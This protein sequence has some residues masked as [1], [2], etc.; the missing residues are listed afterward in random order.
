MSTPAPLVP[1]SPSTPDTMTMTLDEIRGRFDDATRA[2]EGG[3]LVLDT[4]LLTACGVDPALVASLPGKRLRLFAPVIGEVNDGV[5][6]LE[7]DADVAGATRVR[8]R[9]EVRDGSGGARAFLSAGLDG[10]WSFR[11]ALPG[12]PGYLAPGGGGDLP[13][14]R[15]SF[16]Y[17]LDV[18]A[19][20]VLLS[21][22][23]FDD[24]RFGP[25][26]PGLNLAAGVRLEGPL[27][28]IQQWGVVP[29]GLSL[30]G[31]LDLSGARPFAALSIKLP[32]AF[33]LG[34]VS[35]DDV[36]LGLFCVPRK[37][38]RRMDVGMELDAGVRL[39]EVA[40]QL[41]SR[42]EPGSSR[43]AL[44]GWFTG[45]S[46]RNLQALA[47]DLG[48]PDLSSVLPP[49]L[50]DLPLPELR[51]GRVVF[52]L[53]A[54]TLEEVRL[55]VASPAPWPLL[56]GLTLDQ[57]RFELGI[58]RPLDSTR[59]VDAM[60]RG[61]FQLADGSFLFLQGSY[62]GFAIAGG[63]EEG[64]TL[65][66]NALLANPTLHL[67]PVSLPG[68]PV[69]TD[70]GFEATPGTGPYAFHLGVEG[71]WRLPLELP[72]GAGITLEEL[73]LA[74]RY[75][76]RPS[77]K[78]AGRIDVL[79]VPLAGSAELPAEGGTGVI[80]EAGT[81]PGEDV[82]LRQLAGSL[83][84]AAQ[85]P[86]P[87]IEGDIL[88]RDVLLRVDTRPE[89]RAFVLN[90]SSSLSTPL[91]LPGGDAPLDLWLGLRD[92][93]YDFA[94]G[95][96]AGY[97]EGGIRF[98]TAELTVTAD[99]GQDERK[100][101]F[102]QGAAP[103]DIGAILSRFVPGGIALPPELPGI[104]GL[105]IS[106]VEGS[107]DLTTHAYAF[108]GTASI[109]R[110]TA[111]TLTLSE[112]TGSLSLSGTG[113]ALQELTVTVSA[114]ARQE[115]VPELQVET[116]TFELHLKRGD[117]GWEWRVGGSLAIR[118]L[119][120]PSLT[121]KADAGN[122]RFAFSAVPESPLA[123]SVPGVVEGSFGRLELE[124]KRAESGAIAWHLEGAGALK[125]ASLPRASG[126]L[127]IYDEPGKKGFAFTAD[128]GQ[129]PLTVE[130]PLVPG[131]E[132]MT[133]G[134]T[135]RLDQFSILKEAEWEVAVESTLRLIVPR[136]SSPQSDDPVDRSL[137]L[138]NDLLGNPVTARLAA[139]AAGVT[140]HARNLPRI[141]IPVP[142]VVNGE[143]VMDRMGRIGVDAI[144]LR[145]GSSFHAE[146][147]LALTLPE[148]INNVFGEE[149]GKPR[150]RLLNRE[151]RVTLS[152][153]SARGLG[154]ELG[155]SPIDLRGSGLFA[156]EVEETPA[157]PRT[158]TRF[159]LGPVTFRFAEIPDPQEAGKKW[160]HFDFAELGEVA[161]LK[162]RLTFD[163][164]SFAASGG[165][166]IVRDV[167]LPAGPLRAGMRQ[168]GLN[169]L[170]DA[171]PDSIPLLDLHVLRDDGAG[172]R[173]FDADAFVDVL[174]R[175][176]ADTG[177]QVPV[178]EL[179]PVVRLLAGQ[180]NRLPEGF[181]EYLDVTIPRQLELDIAFTPSAGFGLKLDVRAPRD[182]LR[183]LVPTPM[184]FQGITL[185]K[186]ALGELLSGS[187]LL[188][189]VDVA[190]DQ[191][192]I[193]SLAASLFL[194]AEVADTFTRTTAIQ[195]RLVVRDVMVLVIL[196]TQVPIP[197]P[198]W[199]SQVGVQRYGLEGLEA[200]ALLNNNLA[201]VTLVTALRGLVD[202]Y[203]E[204]RAFFTDAD[205]L[206]PADL[207]SRNG[208]NLGVNV[209]PGFVRLPRYVG[210]AL[211]GSEETLFT[212][213]VDQLLVPVANF[214]KKPDPGTIL[215]IVPL[216]Y[217]NGVLGDGGQGVA[218]GPFRVRAAWLFSTL[219]ELDTL[220]A[221]LPEERGAFV[222]S[223]QATG[224]GSTFVQALRGV[225]GEAAG[226]Q[227]HD[228]VVLYLA[229]GVDLAVPHLPVSLD[230]YAGVL[231]ERGRGVLTQFR[232]AGSVGTL[233]AMDVGGLFAAKVHPA[234]DGRQPRA[235][236]LLDG[237]ARLDVLG[238]RV[239]DAAIA[240]EAGVFT[241][242]SRLSLFP[243][244]S[245]FTVDAEVEGRISNDALW[246]HG[247]AMVALP[248]LPLG[249]TRFE[250][251]YERATV[252]G[253]W[254]GQVWT[255]QL[256]RVSP[257][258]YRFA[259]D[260]A[261]P[262]KLVPGLLELSHGEDPA[263]GPSL[264]LTGPA[265]PAMQLNGKVSVP[266]LATHGV[267]VVNVGPDVVD[268]RLETL[269]LG[270][271][272]SVLVVRGDS[273]DRPTSLAF[274]ATFQE[275]L[276]TSF[277]NGM[278]EGFDGLMEQARQTLSQ[279]EDIFNQEW[280]RFTRLV[281]EGYNAVRAGILQSKQ[282]VESII[283][284]LS[285]HVDSVLGLLQVNEGEREA[286][287]AFIRTAN[288]QAQ[289]GLQWFIDQVAQARHNLEGRR[290]ELTGLDDWYNGLDGGG[291]FWN[292]AYYALTR[293]RLVI[294]VEVL[295]HVLW[296]AEQ[297][298]EAARHAV[299]FIA[300]AVD[301]V[302][303]QLDR[304][305]NA[306]YDELQ[307]HKQLI[308]DR[309]AELDH[310]NDLLLRKADELL[311]EFGRTV[312]STTRDAAKKAFETAR[313]VV[314]TLQ[315]AGDFAA[316]QARAAI[317]FEVDRLSVSG[318]L[319]ATSGARF[320][321]DADI[322][323]N[324]FEQRRLAAHVGFEIDF[325]DIPATARSLAAQLWDKRDQVTYL[326]EWE[327]RRREAMAP[328]DAQVGELRAMMAA[329]G[330]EFGETL[331][332]KLL[333]DMDWEELVGFYQYARS[334]I[335]RF[336]VLARV[337][338]LVESQWGPS[339][340][341]VITAL[342]DTSPWAS[343]ARQAALAGLRTLEKQYKAQFA[344]WIRNNQAQIRDALQHA[345]DAA[346]ALTP[347]GAA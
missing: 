38:G 282:Q 320:T 92:V 195:N 55:G 333:Y 95:R 180:F 250:L 142:V 233:L 2:G 326:S 304:I 138:L 31:T 8:L 186:F 81:V 141:P 25:V 26:V 239:V 237:H 281:E 156:D 196:A 291:K 253:A 140:L 334:E 192:D 198:V 248:L 341:A 241:F 287:R 49:G 306:L 252:V 56:P 331:E 327:L 290:G 27:D 133:V 316:R 13:A 111:G 44:D 280:E 343:W 201:N 298:L 310:Y 347:G 244:G 63:L 88:F 162:P 206:L 213:G 305:R 3:A 293:A 67:P 163:G 51:H 292:W 89:T 182:P 261:E 129:E 5:F 209:A 303:E 211:L 267:G 176:R 119:D 264:A 96:F 254:L 342:N 118:L 218:L 57:L 178:E 171:L 167:R 274:T 127:G 337:T 332:K 6:A 29:G 121:L 132:A 340:Q 105:T 230:A 225:V 68:D 75:D 255:L 324:V 270:R 62:P 278:K 158:W 59:A 35:L 346:A 53:A 91:H 39:G 103:I 215:G 285:Q 33:Q 314:D 205:R 168:L 15:E 307:R 115:L 28:F 160:W 336:P 87:P 122:G 22:H 328:V 317:P 152:V 137:A 234:A 128:E 126:T 269:F 295:P 272:R 345:E 159:T 155:S 312:D 174:E 284:S 4:P 125:V 146:A 222:R 69:V 130:I 60:A 11:Q 311:R 90:G 179:R 297:A 202:L 135:F 106:G 169:A 58:A 268:V 136:P 101:A 262:V 308:L 79:G 161:F 131:M 37:K 283:Q 185:R 288:E 120:L 183:L 93:G 108:Q 170:A 219:R 40:V 77:G 85:L 12:L 210:G 94:A 279:A 173:V 224:G 107:F 221:A 78:I 18:S 45:L 323:F 277:L 220:A 286:R 301:A 148:E 116:V 309:K 30:V 184:G 73:S 232:V 229:G 190:V 20:A 166:N 335:E 14:T 65:R 208:L 172:G 36:Y 265:R 240:L 199:F 175:I 289:Q 344:E 124:L 86:L 296:A 153:D 321:A 7:G 329:V 70:L 177:L 98:D 275:D 164:A 216:E 151:F 245:G 134:G 300:E 302:L 226:G 330:P 228:G 19:P 197:V 34:P 23:A 64:S 246:V 66:L 223:L 325:D 150:V 236:L 299:P 114:H 16:F 256:S 10:R 318:S 42:I 188:V 260:A 149:N 266:P 74:L 102:R 207:F 154:F 112:A 271:S 43:L 263:R 144:D 247:G 189:D 322:W 71:N 100:V 80:L 193:V 259:A 104:E 315:Q 194:P 251:T 217:R 243:P 139:S 41:R 54:R 338:A 9:G 113:A 238:H 72:G 200:Q 46:L 319:S 76:G 147:T 339:L 123:W 235:E 181:R 165:F 313:G 24:D 258:R 50:S 83:L 249:E 157:G 187:L 257:D 61:R 47:G 97:F 273:L 32:L 145:L 82:S 21:S 212:L 110:F 17:D 143:L 117:A 227:P 276:F 203:R 242:H 52:D 294:E 109:A 99:I 48:V 1:S 84:A 214:V 191:F 231:V 204:L